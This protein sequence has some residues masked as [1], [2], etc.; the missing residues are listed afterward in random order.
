LRNFPPQVLRFDDIRLVK[1]RIVIKIRT[2]AYILVIT[3]F[4]DIAQYNALP[5]AIGGIALALYVLQSFQ[6]PQVHAVESV[7]ATG[8]PSVS[9]RLDQVSKLQFAIRIDRFHILIEPIYQWYARGYAQ[10]FYVLIGYVID[11]LYQCSERI[12]MTHDQATIAV[13]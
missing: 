10:L 3:L 1:S 7:I 13:S 6:V 4:G 11:L 2:A 5:S 12:G 8:G 9:L